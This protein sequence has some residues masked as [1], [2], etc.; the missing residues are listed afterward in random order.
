MYADATDNTPTVSPTVYVRNLLVLGSLPP[1]LTADDVTGAAKAFGA[2]YTK[3]LLDAASAHG[4][5][6]NDEAVAA[7]LVL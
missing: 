5:R 1:V 6:L 3:D 2:G 7:L 4:I